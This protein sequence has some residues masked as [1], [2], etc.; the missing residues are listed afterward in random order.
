MMLPAKGD[1]V[2]MHTHGTRKEEELY[3][4][5]SGLGIYYEQWDGKSDIKSHTINPGSVTAIKGD[6]FHGIKNIGNKP[7]IIF[8][9]ATNEP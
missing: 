7:L 3:V 2:G 9:I 8:V 5:L 1:S 4:V 6:G